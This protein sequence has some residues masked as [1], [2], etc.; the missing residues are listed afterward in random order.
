M[1]LSLLLGIKRS[2]H[3]QTKSSTELMKFGQLVLAQKGAH[4]IALYTILFDKNCS[5][6]ILPAEKQ[7]PK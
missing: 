2:L 5:Q 7:F 1:I 3:R 4:S 6:Q